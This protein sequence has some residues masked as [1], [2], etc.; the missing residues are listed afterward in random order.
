M[1]VAAASRYMARG[2]QVCRPCIKG[3]LSRIAG[4]SLWLLAHVGTRD[5][6]NSFKAYSASFV[7]EVGIDRT[8]E[9]SATRPLV[10]LLD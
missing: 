8:W 4:C 6:T 5:A 3:L 7:R 9:E 10:H 2:Q 1:V